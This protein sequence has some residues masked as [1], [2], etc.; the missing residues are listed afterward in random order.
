[1]PLIWDME[2]DFLIIGQGIA[3]T[4]MGYRL[5]QAGQSFLIFDLPES[6]KSSRVAAG[7]YNPVTGRKMVKSWMAEYLFPKIE[8]FYQ[9][10]EKKSQEGSF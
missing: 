2:I 6:N 5:E 7:L 1:M 9:E 8:P 10:M 3:G 4:A